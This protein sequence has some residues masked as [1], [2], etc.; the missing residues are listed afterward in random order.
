MATATAET[1]ATF[2]TFVLGAI[3]YIS[4]SVDGQ[5]TGEP[6]VADY[7]LP[8]ARTVADVVDR[9]AQEGWRV[10]GT[11]ELVDLADPQYVAT[12]EFAG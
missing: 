3:A 12:V 11:P 10:V 4:E 8:G 7:L 1:T 9:L 2:V 6:P 5:P